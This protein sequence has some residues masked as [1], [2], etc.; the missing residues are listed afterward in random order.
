MAVEFQVPHTR[1]TEYLIA[2]QHLKI[3]PEL[4]GRHDVPDI[5]ALIE[6]LATLGQLQPILVGRDGGDPYV[7]DGHSRW[8]AA[9]E[10][11]KSGRLPKDFKLRC[12]YFRGNE[13]EE[14]KAAVAA[15]LERNSTTPIDD[16]HNIARFE[17]YGMTEAEIA[18]FYHQQDSAGK[19]DV[20]WVKERLALLSLG[21]EALGAVKEGRVKPNAVQV[22]AK[23]SK[24]QQRQAAKAEHVTAAVCKSVVTG[25]NGHKPAGATRRETLMSHIRAAAD[26]HIGCSVA[27]LPAEGAVQ[28]FAQWLLEECN[29]K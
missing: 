16:A 25:S 17:R 10:G 24:E 26:G 27:K 4:N 29:G 28:R 9:I 3:R 15:N 23:M 1:T 6:S 18:V 8:R 11:M 7:I 21:A 12:V 2:P 5:K 14:F 13:Q 19:P 20:K 22:L